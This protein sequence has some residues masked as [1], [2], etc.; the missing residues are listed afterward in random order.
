MSKSLLWGMV[1]M[2][3]IALVLGIHAECIIRL[4]Y[5]KA[6]YSVAAR[7]LTIEAI[8]VAIFF[9]NSVLSRGLMAGDMQSRS[10]IVSVTKLVTAFV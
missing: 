7:L 6:Q 8:F 5:D 9:W 1:G 10:V 3:L 4:V 2:L